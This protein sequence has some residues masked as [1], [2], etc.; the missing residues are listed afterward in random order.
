[1]LGVLLIGLGLLTWLLIWLK[2]RHRRKVDQQR[3]AISGFPTEREKRAGA[4]SATPDL[5][6]PHQVLESIPVT[7]SA[8]ILPKHMKE[9]NGYEY[10]DGQHMAS[11]G[12][13]QKP[14]GHRE[15]RRS[16]R[17]RPQDQN[18]MAQ[19]NER[20]SDSRRHSSRGKS[21]PLE[22]IV[23]NEPAIGPVEGSRSRSR[24]RRSP[25]SD[26][27]EGSNPEHNRRLREVRGARRN[28][29]IDPP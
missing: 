7:Y 15:K 2:R 4:R 18:E 25:D 9:T 19:M 8:D 11:G 1:M 28:R 6:G 20:P 17:Q 10:Q 5:W 26:L 13:L 21:R 16:R 14:T 27:E 23:S 24:R 3:A 12:V 29:N 22:R